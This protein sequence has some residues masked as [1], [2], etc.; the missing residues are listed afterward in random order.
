[1]GK[2]TSSEPAT[3]TPKG[4][5]LAE[6]L[7]QGSSY[8]EIHRVVDRWIV[9][10]SLRDEAGDVTRSATGLGTSRKTVR[11]VRDEA[12]APGSEGLER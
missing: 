5:A 12:K 2:P 9:A 10:H 7:E 8:R 6:L 1:M 3:V 4:P 11:R